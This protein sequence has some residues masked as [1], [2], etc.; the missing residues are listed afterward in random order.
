MNDAFYLV[1]YGWLN[2]AYSFY[3]E[4]QML[5]EVDLVQNFTLTVFGN[6]SII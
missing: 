3:D 5:N 6:R 4:Y 2:K 1:I